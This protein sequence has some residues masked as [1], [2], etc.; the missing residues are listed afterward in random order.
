MDLNAIINS[1]NSAY[2]QQSASRG[3]SD[4]T[5]SD[6]LRLMAAQLRSGDLVELGQGDIDRYMRGELQ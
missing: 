5:Q 1:A 2:A 3:N 6:F 4:L